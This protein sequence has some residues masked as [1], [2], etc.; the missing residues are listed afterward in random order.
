[1]EADG[2]TV[3]QDRCNGPSKRPGRRLVLQDHATG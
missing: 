2:L 1:M 3:L